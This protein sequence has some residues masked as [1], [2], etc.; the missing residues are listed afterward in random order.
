[1]PAPRIVHRAAPRCVLYAR[2]AHEKTPPD[3]S[4]TGFR[5]DWLWQSDVGSISLAEQA[6]DHCYQQAD[7]DEGDGGFHAQSPNGVTYSTHCRPSRLT[8]S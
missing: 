8:V 1:M 4:L 7:D 2:S 6:F 3:G 5:R